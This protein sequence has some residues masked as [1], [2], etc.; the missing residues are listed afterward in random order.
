MEWVVYIL[1]CNDGSLY[2][3]ITNNL[4]ARLAAHENG[5][6]AKYT[7]G[8]GPFIVKYTEAFETRSEASKR[9]MVIKSF[10]R[11]DKQ[12]LFSNASDCCHP[13]RM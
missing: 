10:S 2:T 7:R 12:A 3:G 9:E 1:E 13:E 5:S 6:G 11:V 4:D 8:R